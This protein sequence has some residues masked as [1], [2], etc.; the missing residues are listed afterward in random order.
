MSSRSGCEGAARA[1]TCQVRNKRGVEPRQH[2]VSIVWSSSHPNLLAVLMVAASLVIFGS[3]STAIGKSVPL[4]K[5]TKQGPNKIVTRRSARVGQGIRLT[6]STPTGRQPRDGLIEVTVQAT[7][8][9]V[10]PVIFDDGGAYPAGCYSNKPMA[11]V[12]D[13]KGKVVDWLP[14]RPVLNCPA[15]PWEM[16]TS[17]VHKTSFSPRYLLQ[18]GKTMSATYHLVLVG[19]HVRAVVQQIVSYAPCTQAGRF[20]VVRTTHNFTTQLNFTL[21]SSHAP[22]AVVSGRPP[23][24]VAV[25]RPKGANGSIWSDSYGF[26]ASNGHQTW[27]ARGVSTTSQGNTVKI[28]SSGCD[29]KAMTFEL[30]AGW[31]GHPVAFVHYKRGPTY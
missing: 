1:G 19:S 16:A 14:H 4:S 11:E 22:R 28:D 31:L 25:A 12:V 26:C 8:V 27:S 7:N 2:V 29:P 17:C 5:N 6:L 3:S 18:P 24:R 20:Q 30:A 10:N 13:N 21:H 9:G 23:S 15:P